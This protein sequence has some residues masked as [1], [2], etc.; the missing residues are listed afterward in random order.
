MIPLVPRW[1]CRLVDV[2][3][4]L[5]CCYDDLRGHGPLARLRVHDAELAEAR[6]RNLQL[7][8]RNVDLAAENDRLLIR[9]AALADMRGTRADYRAYLVSY[10][11]PGRLHDVALVTKPGRVDIYAYFET[12]LTEDERD[13]FEEY[14]RAGTPIPLG[15]IVHHPRHVSE[16]A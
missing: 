15:F 11:G 16:P 9:V 6:D 10:A 12:R 2:L 4:I 13:A 5:R 3:F 1:L 7:A 8:S 14:V